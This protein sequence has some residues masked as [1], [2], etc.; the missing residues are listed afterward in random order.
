MYSA[1]CHHLLQLHFQHQVYLSIFLIMKHPQNF[2]FVGN[3]FNRLP[4]RVITFIRRCVL[5]CLGLVKGLKLSEKSPRV[6]K[7]TT[8]NTL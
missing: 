1:L 7:K 2:L 4:R 6:K 5:N 8:I 3:I